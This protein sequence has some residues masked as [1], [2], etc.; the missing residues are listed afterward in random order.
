MTEKESKPT[1]E[2]RRSTPDLHEAPSETAKPASDLYLLGGKDLEMRFIK[3]RLAAHNVAFEDKDL[4]WEQADVSAY[5]D[6][7]ARAL[8]ADQTPVAVEL[9]GADA[10]ED[11]DF[12]DHHNEYTDRPASLL[13]VLE[14]LGLEPN[15]VARLVAANDSGYIP[16]MQ[17]VLEEELAWKQR[18]G[19]T[20]EQLAK[21]RE[22]IQ[23][24][25]DIVRKK[26]REMQGVTPEMEREAE[27]AITNAERR[28]DGLVIV[29]LNS[30][31]YSPVVDRLYGTWPEDKTKLIVVCS[32]DKDEKEVWFFGDGEICSDLKGHYDEQKQQHEA[33]GTKRSANEYNTVGAGAGFGRADAEAMTL[34]V[35]TDPTEV[36]EYIDT[37]VRSHDKK[38]ED[39][40][41]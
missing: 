32:S 11:V 38:A 34:I 33:S 9:K 1:G 2:F 27:S 18:T 19:K 22:R 6:E 8:E 40:H 17:A 31:R 13:Q 35:A 7:I 26:D 39:R 5:E 28:E 24:M 36:I 10:R 20:P 15:L 16:A 41:E 29:R 30:P 25:I 14:R 21:S 23:R 12:I 3:M 4:R 37:T